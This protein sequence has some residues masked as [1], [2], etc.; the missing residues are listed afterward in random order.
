MFDAYARQIIDPP[1]NAGGRF[2]ASRGVRANHVTLVGLGIGVLGAAAIALD[3]MMV[4]LC[5]ILLSRLA[6]GLDGA[7]ARASRRTDFGGYLDIVCD[8]AFYG[9]VPLGFA[10]QDPGANALAASALIASF[11]INGASFL[12]FAILAERHGLETRAQGL[13]SLYFS[14]GLLEG[15]ETIAFFVLI[16]LW[17]SGFPVAAWIFAGLCVVTAVGRVKGAQKQFFS[18]GND[19]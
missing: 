17:P 16:C 18:E 11:Y 12:G 2:L 1:L 8:F 4:A 19:T 10:M 15:G 3:L 6:D 5:L 14:G 7:V 13:K 9:A